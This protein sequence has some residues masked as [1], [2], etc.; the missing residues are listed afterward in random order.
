MADREQLAALERIAYAR[1][2]VALDLHALGFEV[3]HI[4]SALGMSRLEVR[5][6]LVLERFVRA[7]A[8]H[9]GIGAG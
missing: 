9:H 4:A 5:R 2:V 7:A 1:S 3:H 6:L 8:A